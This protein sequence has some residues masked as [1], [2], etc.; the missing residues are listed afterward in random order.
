MLPWFRSFVRVLHPACLSFPVQ[1]ALA[2]RSFSVC[3]RSEDTR[4]PIRFVVSCDNFIRAFVRSFMQDGWIHG[5]GCDVFPRRKGISTDPRSGSSFLVVV[6]VPPV[7][8][9]ICWTDRSNF[10]LDPKQGRGLPSPFPS[11]RFEPRTSLLSIRFVPSTFVP[12]TRHGFPFVEA[13]LPCF[14]IPWHGFLLPLEA[15]GRVLLRGSRIRPRPSLPPP[16]KAHPHVLSISPGRVDRNWTIERG[17]W[18]C[19]SEWIDWIPRSPA[20]GNR[21]N[22]VSKADDP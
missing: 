12:R 11:L 4:L 14:S 21:W 7:R 22:A 3:W 16:S 20:K 19:V 6:W 17:G 15:R 13:S 5:C 2:R 10:T 9:W 18:W 8:G 1:S